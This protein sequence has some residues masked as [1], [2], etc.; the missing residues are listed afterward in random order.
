MDRMP[1]RSRLRLRASIIQRRHSHLAFGRRQ[2]SWWDVC[3]GL[4][5]PFMTQWAES[6]DGRQ[7]DTRR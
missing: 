7:I 4:L 2:F 3:S 5:S 1:R 6:R